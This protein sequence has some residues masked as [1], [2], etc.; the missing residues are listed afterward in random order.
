MLII[1]EPPA[2]SRSQVSRIQDLSI[3][4]AR[5]AGPKQSHENPQYPYQ[6]KKGKESALC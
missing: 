3:V 4:L 6:P 5:A 2:K 1:E